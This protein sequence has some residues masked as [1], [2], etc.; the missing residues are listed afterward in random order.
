MKIIPLGLQFSVP[1]AIKQ[2]NIREYSYSL[3]W[4]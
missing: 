4:L 1:E 3:D 2:L